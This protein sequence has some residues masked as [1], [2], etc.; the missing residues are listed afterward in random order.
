MGESSHCCRVIHAFG[1][2][3]AAGVHEA[4]HVLSRACSHSTGKGAQ[5]A[6]PAPRALTD[7]QGSGTSSHLHCADRII[8]LWPSM[9]LR[10]TYGL[11]EWVAKELPQV[12]KLVRMKVINEG[13]IACRQ[14][15]MS[16][17]QKVTP[18]AAASTYVNARAD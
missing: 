9:S 11:L 16:T 2:T 18:W 1:D 4:Q 5:I 12:E 3:P 15:F 10:D 17:W 13:K 14:V 6:E 7:P 8:F